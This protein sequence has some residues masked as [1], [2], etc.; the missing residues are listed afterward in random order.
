MRLLLIMKSFRPTVQNKTYLTKAFP[1]VI[2]RA[3]RV[4]GIPSADHGV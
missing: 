4:C 3:R 2:F 1:F